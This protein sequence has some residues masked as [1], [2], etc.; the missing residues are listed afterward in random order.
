[1]DRQPGGADDSHKQEQAAEKPNKT[2]H[3]WR[4]GQD[5]TTLYRLFYSFELL[6]IDSDVGEVGFVVDV[7]WCE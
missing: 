7:D 3:D 6:Y 1:M 4:P 5:R 2:C